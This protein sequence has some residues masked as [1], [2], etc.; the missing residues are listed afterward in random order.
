MGSNTLYEELNLPMN[1]SK[2]IQFVYVG[3]AGFSGIYDSHMS[4]N[5]RIFA[6]F[7]PDTG[8]RA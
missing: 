3:V 8:N 6:V 5:R 4:L 1:K 7:F 2:A